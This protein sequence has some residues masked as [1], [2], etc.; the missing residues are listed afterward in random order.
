MTIRK[1][2]CNGQIH[3]K[4]QSQFVSYCQNDRGY[5]FINMLLSFFIYTIII[6]S[7]TLI[8]HFLIS[9]A[10]H[11]D[12]LKPF[13]WELF[14][15]QLQRELKEASD[16]NVNRTEVTLT[17]KEGQ[18]VSINHYQNL[19]RRQV[20]GRGHEI[21]LLNVKNVEFQQVNSGV[22][23]TVKSDSGKIYQYTFHL[24]KERLGI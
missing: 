23:L 3:I 12:D 5:S 14:V 8:L 2:V 22:S 13:E 11:P 9:N 24:F 15:I 16:I 19:I 1:L 7:L 10:Q 21:F 18:D 17:N 4:I 6:T 20:F